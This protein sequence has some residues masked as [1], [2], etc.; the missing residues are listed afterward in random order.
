MIE[1]P[2]RPR[3]QPGLHARPCDRIDRLPLPDA[4]STLRQ[5]I[6]HTNL[7]C[8]EHQHHH[9]DP[10]TREKSEPGRARVADVVVPD[11]PM[12]SKRGEADVATLTALLVPRSAWLL[13][14]GRNSRSA[15]G[16][17][18]RRHT[19][20]SSPENKAIRPK[21]TGEA[22]RQLLCLPC[23]LEEAIER[24]LAIR[25]RWSYSERFE[26]QVEQSCHHPSRQ[27]PLHGASSR[28]RLTSAVRSR[29][30][31]AAATGRIGPEALPARPAR[32][33]VLQPLWALEAVMDQLAMTPTNARK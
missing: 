8:A 7:L 13:R 20:A 31:R 16:R 14:C 12:V 19:S 18:R 23:D 25:V 32:P 5:A 22:P 26:L 17:R 10:F 11:S 1:I 15:S 4:R 3:V 27:K 9:P 2:R 24:S 28:G 33:N 21:Q 30:A 29:A 6:F